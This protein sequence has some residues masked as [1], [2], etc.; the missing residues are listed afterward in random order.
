MYIDHTGEELTGNRRDYSVL[1]PAPTL[2]DKLT[3]ANGKVISIGKIADIYAHQG[4][5]ETIKANGNDALFQATLDTSYR[6]D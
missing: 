5:T 4:I 1:P 3:T 2:L 6:L